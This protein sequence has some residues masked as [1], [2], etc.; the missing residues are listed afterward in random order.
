MARFAL[1]YRKR[2]WWVCVLEMK[3]TINVT[4]CTNYLVSFITVTLG[5]KTNRNHSA[6][7][8]SLAQILYIFLLKPRFCTFNW[9]TV[10]CMM[11]LSNSYCNLIKMEIRQLKFVFQ[12]IIL[13]CVH[14][15]YIIRW[16]IFNKQYYL[17]LRFPYLAGLCLIRVEKVFHIR[18]FRE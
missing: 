4:Y 15:S 6:A 3:L 12:T 1:F 11:V 10:A 18:V 17:D 9:D 14:N 2:A 5:A 13:C 7:F 8:M 16:V